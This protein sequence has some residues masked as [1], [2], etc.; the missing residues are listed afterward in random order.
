MKENNNAIGSVMLIA[1][2]C[3]SALINASLLFSMLMAFGLTLIMVLFIELNDG[4]IVKNALTNNNIPPELFD[5][6]KTVFLIGIGTFVVL[7]TVI[8]NLIT[9]FK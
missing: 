9:N 1:M 8:Y 6:I 7:T 4:D 3:Y 5:K 2:F